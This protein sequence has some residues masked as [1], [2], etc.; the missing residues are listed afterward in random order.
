MQTGWDRETGTDIRLREGVP[1]SKRIQKFARPDVF[2]YE[3]RL[4]QEV[5][6]LMVTSIESP[7]QFTL[8]DD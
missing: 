7:S 2:E 8:C 4:D 3:N 1:S 6:N 5:P